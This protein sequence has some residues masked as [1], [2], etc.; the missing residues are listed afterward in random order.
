MWGMSAAF[1][2]TFFVGEGDL[3]PI[4]LLMVA[5][6]VAYGCGGVVGP[7][8]LADVIDWDESQTGER[9]E[10]IY[11][12]A[13]GISWKAAVAVIGVVAGT[14]LEASGFQP[15]VKQTETAALTLHALFSLLPARCSPGS[16]VDLPPLRH[17]RAEHARIRAVIDARA[18]T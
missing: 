16:G 12:A 13:W 4:S 15:N 3:V 7:S 18:R 5:A 9:R 11:S 1:G 2:L 8:L 6:G 17:R 10:G 14:A